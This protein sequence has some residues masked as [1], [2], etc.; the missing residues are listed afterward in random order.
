[1]PAQ[2]LDST[3]THTHTHSCT[4]R[5]VAMSLPA[6]RPAP[7][8]ARYTP[9][10]RK[11]AALMEARRWTTGLAEGRSS[12]GQ[13]DA[14]GWP[15]K[16]VVGGQFASSRSARQLYKRSPLSGQTVSKEFSSVQFRPVPISRV[17]L[18]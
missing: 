16:W 3:H 9:I 14:A 11:L 1:M 12:F 15:P 5:K 18:C 17:Q 10:A 13:D 7:P 6:L 2:V 4:W 8:L